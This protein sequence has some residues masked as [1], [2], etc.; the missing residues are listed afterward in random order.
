MDEYILRAKTAKVGKDTDIQHGAVIEEN[1]QIGSN[2]FIGYYAL[3]ERGCVIEDE[4]YIGARVLLMTTKKI[5]HRRGYKP[6]VNGVHICRGARIVSNAIL[7]PGV[8]VGEEAVV[9]AGAVVT[10]DVPARE[11]HFGFP[12]QKRGNVPDTEL[13]VKPK[14]KAKVKPKPTA[15]KGGGK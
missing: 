11:I 9:G 8:T 4:V 13:T 10:K 15:K 1:V 12:A 2:C 7:L 3:I 5:A 14:I 6:E